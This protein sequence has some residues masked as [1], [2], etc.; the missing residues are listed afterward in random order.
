MGMRTSTITEQVAEHLREEIRRGRWETL[1][2]G[3]DRLAREL[4]VSPR[5]V[6]RALKTLEDQGVL[7]SQGGGRKRRVVAPNVGS[8][9]RPLM[10][11][12]LAYESSDE[13]LGHHV[14]LQGELQ[15]AGHTAHY[16]AKSLQDL[17]MDVK[18]VAQFVKR[19]RRMSG[20]FV[21][22]RARCWSGLQ[23]SRCR[24][25]RFSEVPRACGSRAWRQGKI[26]RWEW[27]SG[28]WRIWGTA[29]S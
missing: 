22:G 4:E 19:R 8:E 24:R 16:A 25:S 1:M 11:R 3:K 9:H 27:R 12:I 10:I 2:P 23:P 26:R 5:T 20:W 6:Q 14:H 7:E 29:A 21:P 17:G 13:N 28:V 18:R 15:K